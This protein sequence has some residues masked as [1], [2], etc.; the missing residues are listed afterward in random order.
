MTDAQKVSVHTLSGFIEGILHGVEVQTGAVVKKID[1]GDD[2]DVFVHYDV[3]PQ[4][5]VVF[6]L[7]DKADMLIREKVAEW[8]KKNVFDRV[9]GL[10]LKMAGKDEIVNWLV[11]PVMRS[12]GECVEGVA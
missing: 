12:T 1:V 7:L 2:G 10:E 3:E 11:V 8:N 5:P 6:S 9:I 4:S